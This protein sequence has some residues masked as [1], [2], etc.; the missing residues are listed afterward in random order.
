[1]C[2]YVCIVDR[3]R[4][5]INI[6]FYLCVCEYVHVCVSLCVSICVCVSALYVSVCISVFVCVYVCIVGR[7]RDF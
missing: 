2:V 4:F 7:D 3:D 1:M 6:I 5:L